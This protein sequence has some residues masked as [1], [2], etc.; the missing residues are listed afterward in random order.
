MTVMNMQA[1]AKLDQSKL[2]IIITKALLQRYLTLPSN[3]GFGDAE[4][5]QTH[6]VRTKITRTTL[7][8]NILDTFNSQ[9]DKSFTFYMVMAFIYC[10]FY[11]Y[12]YSNSVYVISVTY[13][14][15][16]R[17]HSDFMNTHKT[18]CGSSV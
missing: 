3:V 4:M 2:S 12:A 5:F 6:R 14:G 11:N 13:K 10:I 15:E 1:D 8:V 16:I 7:C 17:H 9:N 18:L